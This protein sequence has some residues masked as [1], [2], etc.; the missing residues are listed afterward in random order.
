MGVFCYTLL[1]PTPKEQLEQ[2]IN[3]AKTDP[4]ILGFFVDGSQGKGLITQ[5]SDYDASMI[6]KDEAK[7][8]YKDRYEGLGK[9]DIEISILTLEELKENAAWGSDSFWNRYNY[10]H[11]KAQVDKTGEIQ[12]II[13]EK[14]NIPA[15]K[16]E[17][18]INGSLDHF[19]NQV[20]RSVKCQRD[21]NMTASQ[22]EAVESIEPLL[23]ALFGLE[24]RIRPYYK[25]LEWELSNYPLTKL[26]WSKDQLMDTLIKIVQTADLKTQQETL[27]KIEQVF[28]KE[29]FNQVFDDWGEKLPWME[30]YKAESTK[31]H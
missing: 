4:N 15:D 27:K 29:G 1:M 3:T 21:G 19:I 20:Y 25:Y 13:N 17:S 18:F 16:R 5:Y 14:G 28:R 6:V 9:P 23:N 11:L 2:I 30:N 12:K 26:P 8:E 7:Q 31:N 10:V 22:L 24:G